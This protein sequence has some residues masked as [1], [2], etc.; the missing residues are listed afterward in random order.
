MF[1]RQ[2]AS[3]TRSG[4]HV[5]RIQCQGLVVGRDGLVVFVGRQGRGPG[6]EKLVDP[7]GLLLGRLALGS[8]L[9][10]DHYQILTPKVAEALEFY[11]SFGFRLSEYMVKADDSVLGVFLQRKGNPHDI[12]FFDG[13]GPRLHH[14]AYT[15]GESHRL[16]H[17]CDIAAQL[18]FGDNIERGPARHG[19]AFAMFVY[20]RDP[21]LNLIEV[22]TYDR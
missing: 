22:S 12:V 21:D 3:L 20:F 19:P 2:L 17:A 16:L 13:P 1:T 11:M 10:L 7:S 8:A 6:G 4:G 5:G 18:G 14:V 15:S 9:R